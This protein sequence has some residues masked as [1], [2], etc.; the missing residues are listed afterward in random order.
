[1]S[2]TSVR[3]SNVATKVLVSKKLNN[4]P[5]GTEGGGDS[6]LISVCVCRRLVLLCDVLCL[7][8]GGD[9]DGDDEYGIGG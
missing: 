3:A 2:M 5:P 6:F 7:S 8:S 1:M 9:G 4:L